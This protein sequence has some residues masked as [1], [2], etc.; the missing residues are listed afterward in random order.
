MKPTWLVHGGEGAL[1]KPPERKKG[2]RLASD[3]EN[4]PKKPDQLSEAEAA[5][6]DLLRRQQRGEGVDLEAFCAEHPEFTDAVRSS[7]DT[8]GESDLFSFSRIVS[9]LAG[10]GGTTS[11]GGGKQ[12]PGELIGPYKL[13]EKLGEGGFGVVYLAE[14]QQ[15]VRRR[16]AIKVLKAGMDS[17]QVVARFEAERQ[18]LALMDHPNVA[19]VLDAGATDRDR[20][21]FV[22]EHVP[23]SPITDYCDSGRLT[24]AQRL[25]LFIQVCEAVQHAHQKGIIHRDIKPSNVLVMAA[26][27]TTRAEGH[28]LRCRQG[29][30][31]APHRQDRFHA[32]K[33]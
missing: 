25:E 13:L 28:R 5:L 26:R 3:S 20:P 11:G 21:Y 12:G 6:I 30:Q 27:G 24:T 7:V 18:A 4:Q 1:R 2:S 23:G 17:K 22:M 14:Q 29:P 19:K 31:P 16:V 33:V 32:S 10:R 15:P 9:N 8:T